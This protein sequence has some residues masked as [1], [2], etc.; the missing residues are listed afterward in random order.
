MNTELVAHTVVMNANPIRTAQAVCDLISRQVYVVIVSHPVRAETS[1]ASVSFTCGFYNI[2]VIGISN[3][4][5]SLSNKNLHGSFMRTIP[6]Y[7]HQAD[8]WI[9]MLKSLSYQA[10]V[11]IHSNDNDGR[12][13][14]NR[15]QNMADSAK[16]KIEQ[17]IEYEPGLTQIAAE[18]YATKNE[19]A[20]RVYILYA[21]KEDAEAIFGELERQNMTGPGYVWLVSE[22][23]LRAPNKPDG[24]LG[25]VLKNGDN[26][27]A[28]IKDSVKIAVMALREWFTSAPAGPASPGATGGNYNGGNY[29]KPPSDCSQSAGK[30][31]AGLQLLGRLK[32]QTVTDGSTGRIAFDDNGDRLDSEYDIINVVNGKRITIGNYFF[33]KETANMQLRL[34]VDSIEWPGG[35]KGKPRGYFIAT[36]L[37]IATLEEKPFVWVLA[38]LANGSCPGS[39]TPCPRKDHRD[40]MQPACCQGYCVDLLRELAKKLNFTYELYQVADGLYGSYDYSQDGRREF[41]GLIGD[42]VARRADMVVAP[43][44]INPERA[45]VIDFSKPFKFQGI[46][47]IQKRKPR[48]KKMESFLQPFKIELWLL[49]LFAVFVVA[50]VLYVLDRFSPFGKSMQESRL[51]SEKSLNFSSAIWFSFG[52]LLNSGIGEKAPMSFSARVLAMVWAGFS[53]IVVASY[54]ANLAAWLVLDTTETE[55][56]GLDDSRLRNPVEGFKYGTI[57]NSYVDMYFSS[58]VELSNMYRLMEEF[59]M[60]TTEEALEAVRTSNLDVFFWDSPRLEYEAAHDCNLVI[61]GETFAR[62]GYGLGLQKGSFWSERVTLQVLDMHESGFMESLDA[63]WILSS[64]RTCTKSSDDGLQFQNTLGMETMSD[65]FMLVAGG[66]LGGLGLIVIEVAY[67]RRKLRRIRQLRAVRGHYDG[68]G[69]NEVPRLFR[70]PNDGPTRA[71]AAANQ[72]QSQ[73]QQQPHSAMRCICPKGS[74]VRRIPATGGFGGREGYSGVGMPGQHQAHA[75]RMAPTGHQGTGATANHRHHH[76]SMASTPY[77]RSPGPKRAKS[78][79]PPVLQ[80]PQQMYSSSSSNTLAHALQQPSNLDHRSMRDREQNQLEQGQQQLL[81]AGLPPPPP[82]PLVVSPLPKPG[83]HAVMAYPNRTPRKRGN[84]VG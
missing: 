66:M 10:V 17:I 69:A 21:S 67:K 81:D 46:A 4:D 22:Q 56:S 64:E 23:A 45:R 80:Q 9:E 32:N 15:F 84:L 8:V 20:C 47:M 25:L 82:P 11:F 1:P 74:N 36:H 6:P 70:G 31:E 51:T 30:W 78:P 18:L 83:S 29:T 24:L 65:V 12:S 58:Q 33:S 40:H 35:S 44:S 75:G 42:L 49:V 14:L 60:A 3:R 41:N 16:V 43:L 48:A 76:Q 73:Q 79:L 62:S 26:E 72:Q 34:D 28:H 59:N 27:E 38:P 52:V 71:L 7:S 61:S 50:A 5:S 37:K 2:P 19:L 63:K 77:L 53:M 55:I 57:K 68:H 39:S 54:T 13:T